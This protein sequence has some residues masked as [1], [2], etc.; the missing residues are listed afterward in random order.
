MYFLICSLNLPSAPMGAR[1]LPMARCS[2]IKCVYIVLHS[3]CALREFVSVEIGILYNI[4]MFE[5]KYGNE[6][7]LIVLQVYN[8]YGTCFE[9][10]G[11]RSFIYHKKK[12]ETIN[13][14]LINANWHKFCCIQTH[15]VLRMTINIII[16]IISDLCY[17]FLYDY[18]SI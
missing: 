10:L 18:S 16:I 14:L 5:T 6:N 8:K 4:D 17:K 11:S 12:Y 13:V 3:A 15:W 7:T 2:E 9:K 1:F